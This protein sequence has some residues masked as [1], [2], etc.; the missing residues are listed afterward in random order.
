MLCNVIEWQKSAS[1][2]PAPSRTSTSDSVT[3]KCENITNNNTTRFFS[4]SPISYNQQHNLHNTTNKQTQ[5][6]SRARLRRSTNTCRDEMLNGSQGGVNSGNQTCKS[7]LN[8]NTRFVY[9]TNGNNLLMIAPSVSRHNLQKDKNADFCYNSN[10]TDFT[11]NMKRE[12]NTSQRI[13]KKIKMEIEDTQD[14]TS[15]KDQKQ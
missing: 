3:I 12:I 13:M 10:I 9:D 11:T 4:A 2:Q 15:N 8:I 14:I 1:G 6:R 7:N 5:L